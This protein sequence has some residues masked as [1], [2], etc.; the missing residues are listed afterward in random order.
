MSHQNFESIENSQREVNND[1]S[2]GLSSMICEPAM[3]MLD[4]TEELT[5]Q[6]INIQT[7]LKRFKWICLAIITSLCIVPVIVV[8]VDQT[9][10][11][12]CFIKR[13]NDQADVNQ[14]PDVN[15]SVC[16]YVKQFKVQQNLYATVCNQDGHIFVDIR[17]FVNN[18]ATIIGVHINM[19]QWL[20]LKLT[21][22]N[23]GTA[24]SEARVY[25]NNLKKMQTLQS[26]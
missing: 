25:W 7:F 16:V 11:H 3:S 23:I 13:I 8:V 15:R 6:P 17:K 20:T 2:D 10:N 22:H 9:T 26:Q 19:H 21:T 12:A 18:S 5:F 1:I 4:M 14:S 24:I